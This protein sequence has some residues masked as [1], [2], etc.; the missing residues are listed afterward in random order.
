MDG[1][2]YDN[3]SVRRRDRLLPESDALRLLAESEYGFLAMSDTDG[4]PYGIPLNF[5]YDGK[6]SVYLH[7][8]PEGR[9]LQSMAASP[10][11]EFCIVGHTRPM[12]DKFTTEYESV[13]L[14][15]RA[16]VGLPPEERMNALRMILEK[17]CPDYAEKGAVYAERSFGRTEVVRLDIVTASGK[18]KRMTGV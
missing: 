14:R 13:L 17:Y 18:C 10:D 15:C 12:P 5:V 1:F 8:A 7:C 9:K 4:K 16:S 11:V 2:V 6:G 3:S